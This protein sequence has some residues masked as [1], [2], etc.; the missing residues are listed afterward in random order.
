V[1]S[2]LGKLIEKNLGKLDYSLTLFDL[3]KE[4]VPIIREH[5]V[6]D[7]DDEDD[8]N[9]PKDD[10]GQ[11]GVDDSKDCTPEDS[12]EHHLPSKICGLDESHHVCDNCSCK[13]NC[14]YLFRKSNQEVAPT[15]CEGWLV[16]AS[17][18]L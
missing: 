18:N 12:D 7:D 11:D 1:Y 13:Q 8:E 2:K 4:T 16:F 10:E 15:H 14:G 3:I 5:D 6:E 17:I 9:D